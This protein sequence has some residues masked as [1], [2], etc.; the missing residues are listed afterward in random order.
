MKITY[1]EWELFW[2]EIDNDQWFI[3]TEDLPKEEGWDGALDIEGVIC[4][5]GNVFPP[6]ANSIMARSA[7]LRMERERCYEFDFASLV[8]K[9][10]K[11][12]TEDI[13]T[14]SLPKKHNAALL[15]WLKEHEGR[16]LK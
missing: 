6:K 9:W 7:L 11:L 5:Q 13:L 1:V 3:E 8:R 4:Y 16:L 14:V 15:A 12:R 2:A 10:R